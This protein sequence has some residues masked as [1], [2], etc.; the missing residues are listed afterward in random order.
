M[1]ITLKLFFK[2]EYDWDFWCSL[3]AF[4][5]VLPIIFDA[6]QFYHTFEVK[7]L[8]VLSLLYA[9]IRRDQY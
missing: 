3:K 4:L 9:L 8:K 1:V 7:S 2:P 5:T 6:L